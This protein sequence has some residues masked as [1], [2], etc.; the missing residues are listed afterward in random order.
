MGN[1]EKAIIVE[2]VAKSA[3]HSNPL[4]A[5]LNKIPGVTVR[6][7]SRGL[8]YTNGELDDEVEDGEVI[9][10][11]L[12]ATDELIL[13]SPDMLYQGTVVSAVFAR[14]VP[15]AKQPL[16]LL[17]G[18]VDFILTNLRKISY[19][20]YIPIRYMCDC[21]KTNEEKERI[22]TAG[23]DEY[24][25]P[26]DHFIQNTK[27]LNPKDFN[28]MFK[29]TLKN[30]QEVT[31]QPIRFSDFIKLNQVLEKDLEDLD[32]VREYVVDNLAAITL[33]V[34][35]ITDKELIREWYKV[36]PRSEVERIKHK[37][38]NWSQ[39]GIE[40]KYSINCKQCNKVKELTHHLNPVYFF[41][42]PSSPET[43]DY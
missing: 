29:V 7:P 4:I 10:Y 32:Y 12:T 43:L 33:K 13:R 30:G 2:E 38:N 42:L 18:D 36:L 34:D 17:V 9:L 16:E 41:T 6:L 19:G 5:R 15:Q 23:E 11:P 39:W 8:F 20:S 22:H 21:V 25:V 24:L 35:D 14:C 27:E 31:T 3:T 37:L 28:K 40:F 26:V 1:N